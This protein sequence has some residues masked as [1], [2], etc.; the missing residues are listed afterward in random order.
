M[1][2]NYSDI[3]K[4]YDNYRSY[5][6][7]QVQ[8][9]I[10]FG[11]LKDGMKILDVGCGT[12][13][14]SAKLKEY[15]KVTSIGIDKSFGMLKKS[16]AKAL[17]VLCADVE[18]ELPFSDQT[19]EAV[20]GT[21]FLH[22]IQHMQNLISDC[23][24]ILRNNGSIVFLTSSHEQIEQLHP[25]MK[26]FFPSLIER[27]KERFPDLPELDICLKTAGFNNIKYEDL[28]IDKIPIDVSYLEKVKNRFVSTFYLLSEE[29]FNRGIEKLE[30]Y[31]S[32][33]KRPEY[34]EWCG[35]MIFGEKS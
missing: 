2:I 33:C 23:F 19:F 24:R 18:R 16:R 17:D 8:S 29:E 25:V 20:V 1:K 14:L 15:I 35:T 28:T 26:E 34:R 7:M 31:I 10:R 9:L 5:E 12:G 32:N 30:E 21:Y 6:D 11:D 27:D 13:N 22:Y 3:S 4:T